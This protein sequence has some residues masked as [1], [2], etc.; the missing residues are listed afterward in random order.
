[1]KNAFLIIW[2]LGLFLFAAVTGVAL[3]ILQ[4]IV[5][6]VVVIGLSTFMLVYNIAQSKVGL[7]ILYLVSFGLIAGITRA[8]IAALLF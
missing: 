6:I 1:M 3:G 5:S 8:L 4:S 7:V 2:S